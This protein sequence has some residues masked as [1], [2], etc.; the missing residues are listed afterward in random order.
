MI[1]WL[2]YIRIPDMNSALSAEPWSPTPR[3][4]EDSHHG[5]WSVLCE[6]ICA[7]GRIPAGQSRAV[8]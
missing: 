6:W 8:E 2:R 3:G 5:C 4:I 7:C 1:S